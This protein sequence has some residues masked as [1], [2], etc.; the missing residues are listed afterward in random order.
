MRWTSGVAAARCTDTCMVSQQAG[1]T[2]IEFAR[3]SDATS[4]QRVTPPRRVTSGCASRSARCSKKSRKTVSEVRFSPTRSGACITPAAGRGPSRRAGSSAPRASRCRTGRASG[5]SGGLSE[6]P[7]DVDVHHQRHIGTDRTSRTAATRRRSARGSGEPIFI[8]TPWKPCPRTASIFSIITSC[9]EREPAGV[10][11]V[12]REA[13]RTRPAKERPE[14][15]AEGS[16]IEI[17]Q[18]DVDARHREPVGAR[19]AQ[20]LGLPEHVVPEAAHMERVAAPRSGASIFQK[21]ERTSTPPW[22][23]GD[24]RARRARPSVWMRTTASS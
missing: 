3:A 1:T 8:F 11:A 6:V 20:D 7:V 12:E 22:S 13:A 18:G 17:P 10:R 16:G 14:R 23:A 24:T 15:N 2:R 9:G 5:R 4:S 21:L 19:P